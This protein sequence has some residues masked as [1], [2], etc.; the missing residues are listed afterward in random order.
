[1]RM[2][3]VVSLVSSV[4]LLALPA[5]AANTQL[6]A[7]G[8][9][10]TAR[11]GDAPQD[12]YGLGLNT[13][14]IQVAQ[15][16]EVQSGNTWNHSL[17]GYLF[18]SSFTFSPNLYAPLNF[19][20]GVE[21]TQVCAR[22]FDNTASQEVTLLVGAFESSDGASTPAFLPLE[23]V[24][25]GVATTPGFTLLCATVDPVVKIRTQADI[26][27]NGSTSTVQY[28]VAFVLPV[29]PGLA[30]GPAVVT[31][32][33]TISPPPATATFSD[34]PTTHPFF[35]FVEAMAAA[36]ITGGCGAGIYCPD[37]PITRGEM[38]VFLAAALGLYWPN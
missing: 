2:N 30:V 32:R 15:W 33:R 3:R 29:D 28:W 26:E 19:D 27:G 10:V 4:F 16:Q 12:V 31:W 20:N 25:T 9:P 14:V 13:S 11:A 7:F 6:T 38:S 23:V 22:V 8:Q 34:V 1:M 5:A 24:S 36:G 21:I 18:A 17:P 37:N 35:R